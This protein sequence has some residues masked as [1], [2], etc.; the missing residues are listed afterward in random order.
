[1]TRPK[2]YLGITLV[3]LLI[4]VVV[5]AILSLIAVPN[6]RQYSMRAQRTEAKTALLQLAANQERFYLQ[7]N[8]FTTELS[9][10]GFPTG[11][12]ENGVYT[13]NVLVADTNT[14]QATATPTP[15]GG[16]NGHT[17]TMDAECAEF[18]IDA[19]GLKT[20]QPD[21]NNSCW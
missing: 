7:N 6:Y 15:G 19:L 18:R 3:E 16:T 1:M 11:A 9:L 12:S 21:P 2:R 4:V 8:S 10:L 13:L 20:A 14:Y 5:M 17:M